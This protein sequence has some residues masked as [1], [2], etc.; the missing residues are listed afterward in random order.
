MGTRILGFELSITGLR[1]HIIGTCVKSLSHCFCFDLN[2]SC[3]VR[4]NVSI[5][6]SFLSLFPFVVPALSSS[7]IYQNLFGVFVSRLLINLL[8]TKEARAS[9]W[10]RL[11]RRHSD[12][13]NRTN[14]SIEE[15]EK[16]NVEQNHRQSELDMLFDFIDCHRTMKMNCQTLTVIR[17]SAANHVQ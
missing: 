16:K 12:M 1:V 10:C 3:P 11:N 14:E 15:N 17:L 9:R 6:S 4:L 13:M 5:S 8:F 2:L 7:L